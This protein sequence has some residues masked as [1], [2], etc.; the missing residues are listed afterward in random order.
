MKWILIVY[1][2]KSLRTRRSFGVGQS[3]VWTFVFDP[4]CA[5]SSGK[6]MF[7]ILFLFFFRLV[8]AWLISFSFRLAVNSGAILWMWRLR[9]AHRRHKLIVVHVTSLKY[10]F[11]YSIKQVFLRSYIQ[12]ST[13]L[14]DR[15]FNPVAKF[16][17]FSECCPVDFLAWKIAF[18]SF[19]SWRKYCY[20]FYFKGFNITPLLSKAFAK[21]IS[22]AGRERFNNIERKVLKF[23]DVD[24][25]SW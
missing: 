15:M 11:V 6:S 14:K 19:Q 17:T 2:K 1:I 24:L 16:C 3:C 23:A 18:K 25:V 13:E 8:A 4:P 10:W 7:S 12:P 21:F 22:H 9:H 5:P 20:S